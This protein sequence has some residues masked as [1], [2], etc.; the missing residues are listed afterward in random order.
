MITSIIGLVEGIKKTRAA[1][2]EVIHSSKSLRAE[3]LPILGKVTA[4]A[5]LLHGLQLQC[6]LDDAD[7]DRVQILNYIEEPLKACHQAVAAILARLKKVI[8]IGPLSLAFGKVLNKE[9]TAALHILDQAR[10]V[11]DL[12][13]FADQRWVN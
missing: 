4:F 2:K 7:G 5:G 6:E 9:T 12:A 1:F 13:L 10:P 3:L 8:A 11:L